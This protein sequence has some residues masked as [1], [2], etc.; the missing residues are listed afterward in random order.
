MGITVFFLIWGPFAAL[1]FVP[2]TTR[3]PLRPAR[4]NPRRKPAEPT[5]APA[6]E[7]HPIAWSQDDH[8]HE[9]KNAA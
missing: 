9:S 8:S 7:F 3:Q 6:N 2:V 1:L 4:I 5:V